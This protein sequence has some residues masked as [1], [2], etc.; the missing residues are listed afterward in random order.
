MPKNGLTVD[1]LIHFPLEKTPALVVEMS[2]LT[3]AHITW[4][5]ESDFILFVLP[6]KSRQAARR[7]NKQ[8]ATNNYTP[9]F[10][11]P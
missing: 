3:A 6:S 1:I 2:S 10:S 5:F 11:N 7:Y 4:T 9:V 8:N